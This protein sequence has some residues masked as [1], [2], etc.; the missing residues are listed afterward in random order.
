MQSSFKIKRRV[1][2]RINVGDVPIGGDAPIAV[3]SMAN[4]DTLDVDATVAQ[5]NALVAAGGDLGLCFCA[6][7]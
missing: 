3:Q 2:R 7:S 6:G 1:S 5:I 4:T